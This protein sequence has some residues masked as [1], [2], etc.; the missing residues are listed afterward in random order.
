M[1]RWYTP[2][3]L[4][5]Y[6]A[7]FNFIIGQRGGGKSFGTL[8]F[9]IDRYLKTGEQFIILRREQ[10]EMDDSKPTLF[11]AIVKEGVIPDHAFHAKGDRLYCD[12]KVMGYAVALSTSMKKKSINY[13]GV[14][15]IIFEEF[16]VDGVNSRYL[17]RGDQE[18]QLFLNF[19]ETVARMRPKQPRVFFVANAFSTVNIYF[20]FFNI[21]IAPP[22]K[23]YQLH[24]PHICVCI[25]S[26]DTYMEAKKQTAFYQLIQDTPFA[27]H[28]YDNKFML[29][30]DH[31]IK[32]QKPKDMEYTF[33]IRY[34]GTTY[35]VFTNFAGDYYVTDRKGNATPHNT[36]SLSLDDNRP[37]NINIR[38]VKNLPA[39]KIFRNSVDENRVFYNNL[40]TYQALNEAIYLLRTIT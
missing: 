2:H 16:M 7:L 28:A 40:K 34:M 33:S 38:R 26:D 8:K 24:G 21:K 19:Y 10:K 11:D 25:W 12:N 35:G 15:W 29:D 39:M 4:L 37:D 17:G 1:V 22:F 30:S 31:F 27:S 14:A 9:C 13:A 23:R 20:T 6:N 5:T 18:V 3:E 36:V 32:K